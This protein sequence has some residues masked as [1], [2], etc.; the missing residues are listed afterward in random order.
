MDECSETPDACGVGE[1]CVNEE[2]RYSCECESG[3]VKKDERCVKEI[4][5][6]M[7]L[8]CTEKLTI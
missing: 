7:R 6:G 3:Y 4:K 5:K 1:R 2:G 8:I